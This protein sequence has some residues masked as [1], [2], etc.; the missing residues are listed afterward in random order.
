M[1]YLGQTVHTFWTFQLFNFSSK[2]PKA[3]FGKFRFSY[4][5]TFGLSALFGYFL[6]FLGLYELIQVKKVCC[7]VTG[8]YI[9]RML[10]HIISLSTQLGYLSILFDILTE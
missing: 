7:R 6:G 8:A 9:S 10:H 1:Q 3:A 5:S 4:L 2:Q